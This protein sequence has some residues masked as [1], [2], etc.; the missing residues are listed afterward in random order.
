MKQKISRDTIIL[1]APALLLVT[2]FLVY[3][4]FSSIGISF[5]SDDHQFIGLKNYIEV[6]QDTRI[7][8]LRGFIDGPPFG[9]LIHNLIWIVVHLPLTIILGLLFAMLFREIRGGGIIQSIIF[10]GMVV[11][12]VIG[13]VIVRFMFSKNAGMISHF[14]GFLGIEKLNTTWIAHP[15]TALIALILT[16]VWLWTGY[17]MIVYLAALT[18]IPVSYYEAARIDGASKWQQFRRITF[19]MLMSATG[20]IIVMT[21]LWEL[22]LFDLV[23]AST[24]GGPGGSTNVMALEMYLTS[25]KFL[26]YGKGTAIAT[27]LT[28]IT[29]IPIAFSVRKGLD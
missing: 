2:I 5:Y 14:M 23:Y 25:F 6:F 7:I 27:I 3:P 24:G 11:P 1:I 21:I 19:P 10:M 16:S 12:M 29:A 17:C 26:E 22:K 20:V 13:G 8:N 15:D 18:T 4:M 9:A 28:L